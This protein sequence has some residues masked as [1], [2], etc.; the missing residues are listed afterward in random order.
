MIIPNFPATVYVST[1][2]KIGLF[3]VVADWSYDN[4]NSP[5]S[6]CSSCCRLLRSY[7]CINRTVNLLH[8]PTLHVNTHTH[9]TFRQTMLSGVFHPVI[10]LRVVIHSLRFGLKMRLS[11]V[12][13][14]L[15]TQTEECASQFVFQFFILHPRSA[16]FLLTRF[17]PVPHLY[18]YD[19]LRTRCSFFCSYLYLVMEIFE[20][21][22]RLSV[23]SVFAVV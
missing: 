7:D 12:L 6:E 13:L 5:L 1:F 21:R 15:P 22:T 11:S 4:L 20:N 3:F 17:R 19:Q 8:S 9:R 2:W 10:R 18:S 23:P 14:L 16:V